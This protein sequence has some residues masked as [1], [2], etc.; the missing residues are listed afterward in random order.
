MIE[1]TQKKVKYYEEALK[2]NKISE[3]AFLSKLETLLHL[4]NKIQDHLEI[5]DLY[6]SKLKSL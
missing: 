1:L 3:E 2:Y 4:D 6:K 5:V